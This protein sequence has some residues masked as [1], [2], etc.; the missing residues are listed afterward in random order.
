MALNEF[1]GASF[2]PSST[3][4]VKKSNFINLFDYSS[5]FAPETHDEMAPIFGNQSVV[6]FLQMLKA[7]SSYASDK[8]YWTEKGRLHTLL[9]GIT[10]SGNVFTKPGH[11]FRVNEIVHLSGGTAKRLALI[12]AKDDDTFTAVPYKANGWGTLGT[13]A[14]KGFVAGSEFL[15]GTKGM[16]GSLD[17][18][19]TILDNKGIILKDKFEVSG[20][21]A[22]QIGWVKTDS[23]GYLW[24]LQSELDTRRRWEDR[25]EL[26]MMVAEKAEVGSGAQ[27]AGYGGTEGMFE[28]IRKRGNGY[29]GFPTQLTDWDTILKRFDQ[30][31]KIKDYTA[32]V[33]RDFS[34]ATDNLLGALNAGYDGGI[35]YG[36]FNNNKDM[37]VNLGFL[38]FRRGTYNFFKTDYKVLNDPTLLGSVEPAEGKTRGILIPMGT[39]EVYEGQGPE[40][41][42]MKMPFLH[43][44]YRVSQT[45]N[46]KYKT[47]LTGSVGGVYTDDEDAMNQHHLSERMLCTVGANNFMLFEGA[48]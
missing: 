41:E 12:T 28:A 1:P 47:W 25:L 7:E 16:Q 44:K 11:V 18:D 3:K 29:G 6:G 9:T 45:E 20:S 21:D 42:K 35:S 10:R 26:M 23:G 31:G 19:F 13:T 39:K 46:R 22:A 33:D 15:K 40:G 24:Y 38:G 34:L 8:Y 27:V 4:T 43:Q 2:T 17:T 37:V 14:I 48:N 5:Q 36:I 32:Y 30:Q